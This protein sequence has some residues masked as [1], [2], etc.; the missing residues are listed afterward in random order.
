MAMSRRV[1]RRG[2]SDLVLLWLWC[3]LAVVALIRPLNWEPP[4]AVS[5]ALKRPKKKERERERRKVERSSGFVNI[6]GHG[7]LEGEP[8][9]N[10]NIKIKIVSI[11]LVL[12]A[13]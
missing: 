12:L 10:F 2:S 13:G 8:K 3:R 9:S 5:A 6:E 11:P 1:G 7:N 4:Y